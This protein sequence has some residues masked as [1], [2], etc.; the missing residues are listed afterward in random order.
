MHMV[1]A[2]GRTMTTCSSYKYQQG[3]F[4]WLSSASLHHGYEKPQKLISIVI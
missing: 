1:P 3:G 2:L 4:F